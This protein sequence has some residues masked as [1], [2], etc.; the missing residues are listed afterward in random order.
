[1]SGA[2]SFQCDSIFKKRFPDADACREVR[3]TN[4][5]IALFLPLILAPSLFL[6]TGLAQSHSGKEQ[7]KVVQVT[8]CLVKGDEPGEVWLAQSD[9]KIYGLE[10]AKIDLNAHLGQKVMVT[11]S[12]QP[13]GKEE[14]GEEAHR[15]NKA[16]KRES[17][18]FRVRMLKVIS[19]SCTQ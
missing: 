17:A 12:I 2:R 1:M 14:G 5:A 16:G 13:E 19:K 10:S 8:G 7:F 3:V 18:D 11:G 4:Y 9:G 6:E 15:E